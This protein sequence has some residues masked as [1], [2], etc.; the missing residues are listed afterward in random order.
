M[1]LEPN[2]DVHPGKL[3]RART[4]FEKSNK[5]S[6]NGRKSANRTLMIIRNFVRLSKSKAGTQKAHHRNVL[7][8]IMHKKSKVVRQSFSGKL[9]N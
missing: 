2:F 8:P 3:S 4:G 1:T 6:K 7:Y 9:A 5:K